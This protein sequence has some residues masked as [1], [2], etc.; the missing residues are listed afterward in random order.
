MHNMLTESPVIDDQRQSS[1]GLLLVMNP[2]QAQQYELN[3]SELQEDQNK[4][5]IS[6]LA[7]HINSAWSANKTAKA[8][9]EKILLECLRQRNGEFDPE[10]LE[11]LKQQGETDPIFMMITDIKCR[12]AAAWLTDAILPS[13]EKPFHFSPTPIP[14]LP[15]EMN[16]YAKVKIVKGL[17][18][19]MAETGMKMQE[20]DRETVL[21]VG[22]QIKAELQE[23]LSEQAQ[24]DADDAAKMVDDEFVEGDWYKALR[25]FIDDFVTFPSAFVKGPIVRRKKSLEWENGRPVVK[26]K[27]I[28]QYQRVSPFD[29]YPSSGAKTLNDGNLIERIRFSPSDLQGMIEVEGYD[30]LAIR[31]V[32]DQYST[33]GLREWISTDSERAVL[34]DHHNEMGDPEPTI[35]C[36]KFM[37]NIQGK[38]LIE[39]GIDPV[40]IPDPHM[41]YPTIAHK[42]GPYIISAR[43]NPHPLGNRGYYGASFV[44]KN[45][46]IWGRGVAQLV[47]D[48]QRMCNSAARAIARN[49]GVASGPQVWVNQSRMDPTQDPNT[50]YPWKVWNFTDGEIRNRSDIPMGF[51][52]PRI[53]VQELMAI[54]KHFYDQASE[55]SGIPAYMYGS[56]KVGGAGRTATGLSILMNAASKGLRASVVHIDQGV[57]IPSVKT[58]WTHIMLTEPDKASGDINVVARA[59]DY[60]MQMEH[61]QM[62]LHDA[63]A[64]TNNQV[65]MQIIGAEGRGEMLREYFKRLKMPVDKIVPDRDKIIQDSAEQRFMELVQNLAQQLQV[66]PRQ[67][68]AMSQQQRQGVAQ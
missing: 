3:Q 12:N 18:Q 15:A 49:M 20:L 58:H 1:R 46:S 66:D 5:V 63:L 19:K 42:I 41:T 47:R 40:A 22:E 16:Q 4:P 43:L 14:T 68:I 38:A 32:L 54:Y 8:P 10:V 23:M 39:W 24:S 60:L 21:E 53:I 65:D 67:L 27:I 7:S 26:S 48:N 2:E 25:E 62:A 31:A 55:V 56:E 6:S 52:M 44:T 28:R 64:M 50:M 36:L 13:G 17:Q 57:I 37:G 35:D 61:M 9:I 30:E 34:E 51:F 11:R 59:S 33:G 29:L 45:G